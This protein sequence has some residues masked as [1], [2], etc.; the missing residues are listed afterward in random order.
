[1]VLSDK[2]IRRLCFESGMIT[3]FSERTIV[4]GM[5]HGLSVCGYD[6]RIAQDLTLFPGE[7]AL[8]S[9]MERFSMPTRV[10]GRVHDKSTLA[11]RGVAVQ[12]T[13]IEPGWRGFLTLELTNHGKSP[14]SFRAG[15]PVCQVI[16]DWLDD[17]PDAPYRGKYQDQ[18]AEPTPAVYEKKGDPR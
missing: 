8:A 12:N 6:L 4:A 13:V 17:E 10:V 5:S 11:R 9:A 2:S 18:P 7:F 15:D 3:P 16:F 14:V 1:M